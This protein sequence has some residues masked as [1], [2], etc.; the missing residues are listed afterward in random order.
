MQFLPQQH[1]E[2][3]FIWTKLSLLL[4]LLVILCYLLRNR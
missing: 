1:H 3:H 4:L 2:A